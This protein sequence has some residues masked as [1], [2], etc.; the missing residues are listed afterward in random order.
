MGLP[1]EQIALNIG[2]T[3][4]KDILGGIRLIYLGYT[5][6]HI[7]RQ[8]SFHDYTKDLMFTDTQVH[9]ICKRLEV[10]MPRKRILTEIGYDI[11]SMDDKT[12]ARYIDGIKSI[13]LGR[14]Y[15]YIAND[16]NIKKRSYT[17]KV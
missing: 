3:E 17:R 4:Y 8:Y 15:K 6:K 2:P 13:T 10:N 7:A 9:E 14:S 11:N 16:Y 1:F 5:W 12:L